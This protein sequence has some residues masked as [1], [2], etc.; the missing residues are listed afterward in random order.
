MNETAER[1]IGHVVL[2]LGSI[3]ELNRPFAGGALTLNSP[4]RTKT[5]FPVLAANGKRESRLQIIGLR[6]KR[7]KQWLTDWSDTY[8]SGIINR[9][10]DCSVRG[11]TILASAVCGDCGLCPYEGRSAKI[12]ARGIAPHDPGLRLPLAERPKVCDALQFS[13][14]SFEV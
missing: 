13:D 6:V 12:D 7:A 11:E 5:L 2:F 4:T 3:I 1:K 10:T 9:T 14:P 8:L